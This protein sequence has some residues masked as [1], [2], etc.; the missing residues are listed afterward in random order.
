MNKRLRFGAVLCLGSLIAVASVAGGQGCRSSNQGMLPLATGGGA[1][2]TSTGGTT[3][4]D[5]FGEACTSDKQC[6]EFGLLCDATLGCVECVAVT[7][8]PTPSEGEPACT[9]GRCG[10]IIPCDNSLDCPDDLVCDAAAGHCVECTGNADCTGGAVC[11]QGSCIT[12]ECTDADDC[13]AGQVC[14]NNACETVTTCESTADCTNQVC[15]T[16]A[17]QCVECLAPSDCDAG[18][19]CTNKSCAPIQSTCDRPRVIVLVQRSGAMFEG[20]WWDSLRAATSLID[21]FNATLDI[22]VSLF[23][24]ESGSG[25]CPLLDNEALPAQT[26]DVQNL[27]DA[28]EDAYHDATTN[29]VKVDAPLPEAVAAATT[30]LSANGN[31]PFIVLVTTSIPDSCTMA[32]S[33]CAVD[34]VIASVQAAKAAGVTSYVLGLKDANFTNQAYMLQAV[35]NAGVGQPVAELPI[36]IN[37]STCAITAQG[38][39]AQ[40]GGNAVAYIADTSA[41]VKSGL[42]SIFNQI[43]QSCD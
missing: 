38:T 40:A 37:G 16:D 6:K 1:G 22:G 20:G 10:A 39:Y 14:V 24:R 42:E 3:S 19:T 28:A 36:E 13:D 2:S 32:D 30:T 35:A 21:Q 27:M 18:E 26:S 34:S 4:T 29:L 7:D 12:P 41:D 17:G 15:D 9:A 43:A 33:A 25:T 31:T 23:Y 8:C 5:G 11:V